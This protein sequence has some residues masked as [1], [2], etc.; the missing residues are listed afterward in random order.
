[1]G[2]GVRKATLP[3]PVGTAFP[4]SGSAMARRTVR[5][6]LMSSSVVSRAYSFTKI[7][8]EFDFSFGDRD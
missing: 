8:S 1:M 7:L 5:M 6:E 4:A 3:A 2:P